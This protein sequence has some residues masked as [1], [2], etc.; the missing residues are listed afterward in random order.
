MQQMIDQCVQM[1]GG[2]LGNGMMMGGGMMG[3]MLGMLL[4]GTLLLGAVIGTGVGL[5]RRV[6]HAQAG[7]RQ[8]IPLT[9]LQERFAR[10]DI[11]VEEYQQRRSVLHTEEHG[12]TWR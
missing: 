1:M 8:P 3:G 6:V 11:G 2:M 10:G 12:E 9:L 4:V 7:A 5:A